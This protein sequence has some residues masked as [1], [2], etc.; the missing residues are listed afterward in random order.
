VVLNGE[1]LQWVETDF[2]LCMFSRD[3][4]QARL[5]YAQFINEQIGNMQT[6]ELKGHPK[7]RRVLGDD[8]F[9][10]TLKIPATRRNPSVTLEQLAQEICAQHRTSLEHMQSPSRDRAACKAR[11]LLAERAVALQVASLSDVARFLNR[12]ASAL[13]RGIDRHASWLPK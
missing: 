2:A 9:L 3:L 1:I 13:A 11:A 8:R 4:A 5:L 12:S 7:E 6:L 10:E